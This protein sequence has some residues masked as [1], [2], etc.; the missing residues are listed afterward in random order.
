MS[1]TGP[2]IKK[3]NMKMII[4]IKLTDNSMECQ[5]KVQLTVFSD[6][7]VYPKIYMHQNSQNNLKKK[8]EVGRLITPD[9]KHNIEE[10]L[11]KTGVLA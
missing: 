8:K 7:Q 5:L 9:F 10:Q 1:H 3:L 11:S 2:W 4:F 6:R